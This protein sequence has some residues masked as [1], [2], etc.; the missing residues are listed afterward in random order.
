MNS[1]SNSVKRI[2]IDTT[3]LF[4]QYA[5]RGIGRTG[6]E[7]IY[8]LIPKFLEA[9]YEIHIVGFE[10]LEKNLIQLGFSQF[11][12]E[13]IIPRIA[14]TSLG[15][16][17]PSGIRNIFRW[18]DFFKPI[19]ED[20][21]P[22]LFFAAHFERGLPTASYLKKQLTYV[23]KT[24]VVCHDVIPLKTNKYTNKDFIRNLVKKYLYK[25]M[26]T[27]V[28]DADL[29]FTISEFSKNEIASIPGVDSSKIKAI[30]WGI[31]ESFYK[32]N[33]QMEYD[34]ELVDQ[35]LEYFHLK[36]KTYFYYDSGIESNK[37]IFELMNMFAKLKS[38]ANSKIPEY[39][40]ITGGDFNK[41]LGE[42]IKAK[43]NAAQNILKLAKNLGILNNIIT[44]D[45]VSDRDL[46]ILLSNSKFYIN[47]SR[48]EGFGLGIAQAF[49]AEV[50]V[51]ASNLSCY[52]EITQDAALLVNVDDISNSANEIVKFIDSDSLVEK[53]ILKGKEVVKNYNWENT[54]DEYFKAIGDLLSK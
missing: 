44:T 19:I 46:L 35:V 14:F 5:Q 1:H 18:G 20:L 25:K 4:D 31:S 52:P 42:G 15:E 39:L 27:G 36:D 2:L 21:K 11:A 3:F 48:Y 51:I 10:T 33:I 23:P 6:K 40:V 45:R 29:I 53:N 8:R 22:D 41:G 37:G 49:A 16:P 47:L 28:K 38:S 32:A 13:E 34:A 50:P 54:A 7:I 30:Y 12:I 17:V 26:W 43:N 9:N 24:A